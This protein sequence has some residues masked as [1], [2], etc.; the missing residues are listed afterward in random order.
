M[1]SHSTLFTVASLVFMD[2]WQAL[3]VTSPAAGTIWSLNTPI[4]VTWN[5]VA[6]DPSSFDVVLVNND[7]NCA[8]IGTSQVVQSNVSTSD[9]HCQIEAASSVKPCGGYQINLNSPNGGILAQSARFNLSDTPAGPSNST[10]DSQVLSN[11]STST[12]S[13]GPKE[14]SKSATSGDTKQGTFLSN[15][16]SSKPSGSKDSAAVTD[17]LLQSWSIFLTLTASAFLA[18]V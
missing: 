1:L 2:G 4:T 10:N 12:G 14:G 5:S 8:P 15:S 9:G 3:Q 7:A 17:V 18:W 6:S 13:G 11:N 16:T